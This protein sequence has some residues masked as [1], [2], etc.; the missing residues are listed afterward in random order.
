MANDKLNTSLRLDVK[1]LED[2]DA[3]VTHYQRV[4][5]AQG[6]GVRISRARV[7]EILVLDKMRELRE[8]GVL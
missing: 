6:V 3:L 8:G 4:Y 1:R 2:M 5:Q 7:I